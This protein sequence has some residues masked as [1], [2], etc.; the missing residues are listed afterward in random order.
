MAV[1][2]PLT[3][4]PLRPP[5]QSSDESL[6]SKTWAWLAYY[7]APRRDTAVAWL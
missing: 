7:K 1:A 6:S 4:A 3:V 5:R 2:F